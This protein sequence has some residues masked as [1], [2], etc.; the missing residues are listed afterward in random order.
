MLTLWL[1]ACFGSRYAGFSAVPFSCVWHWRTNVVGLTLASR[2]R[3]FLIQRGECIVWRRPILSELIFSDNDTEGKVLVH[4]LMDSSKGWESDNRIRKEMYTL[5][6]L[7]PSETWYG[8][9]SRCEQ[10]QSLM[11]SSKCVTFPCVVSV[12][13]SCS[14]V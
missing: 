1:N 2:S 6:L 10:P 14:L 13:H 12:S 4:V 5:A 11:V 9:G 7:S 8:T 3:V